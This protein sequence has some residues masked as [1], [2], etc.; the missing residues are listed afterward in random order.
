MKSLKAWHDQSVRLEEAL[1]ALHLVAVDAR[2]FSD[3]HPKFAATL[4]ASL[5]AW[6]ALLADLGEIELKQVGAELIFHDLALQ[7]HLKTTADFTAAMKERGLE[8]LVLRSGL[9]RD[10]LVEYAHYMRLSAERRKQLGDPGA[11]LAGHGVHHLAFYRL[12]DMR[13]QGPGGETLR[14]LPIALKDLRAFRRDTLHL[15][16]NLYTGAKVAQV[17]DLDV[18]S[19]I[20]D[21]FLREA[22]TH[23]SFLLGLSSLK[24]AD[25]YTSTHSLNVCIL[26]ICLARYIGVPG[27]MLPK[28]GIAC[29]LHD[30]GKMFLPETLLNKPGA[31]TPEEWAVME[32][33]TTLGARF[34]ISVPGL[35]R[36]APLV[37]YEHHMTPDGGGYPRPR[38]RYRVNVV[39]RIAALADFYDALS[40]HRPYKRAIPPHKV[41]EIMQKEDGKMDVQLKGLFLGMLGRYPIGTVVRLD[42]G[43][44]GVVSKQSQQDPERPEVRLT[45]DPGGSRLQE[46]PAVD[47]LETANGSGYKRSIAAPVDPEEVG[48]DPLE[49]LQGALQEYRQKPPQG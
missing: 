46:H 13:H 5:A 9:T 14:G 24:S 33:H 17:L 1:R 12:S 49:V 29:L 32:H 34:L 47:L 41:V 43:E 22:T 10:E 39:S 25:E 4:D 45:T 30:I 11:Y 27:P 40:T 36:L 20:V 31:L 44:L 35:P 21:L 8:C 19:G 16:G 7:N 42:T 18:A 38:R 37:A 15:I 2:L 28:V 26:S 48:M 6:S 3:S 23:S